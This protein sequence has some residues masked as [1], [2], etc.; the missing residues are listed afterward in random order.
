MVVMK[1]KLIASRLKFLIFISFLNSYQGEWSIF[2]ILIAD[3]GYF[4]F[5]AKK[6]TA[7][8]AKT[9]MQPVWTIRKVLSYA[10]VGFLVD[11][12]RGPIINPRIPPMMKAKD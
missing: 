6:K 11:T 9:S 7:G 10:R 8:R 5:S 1:A 3:G 12:K 4:G 2:S